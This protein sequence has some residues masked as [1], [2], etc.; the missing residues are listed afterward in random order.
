MQNCASGPPEKFHRTIPVDRVVAMVQAEPG[1]EQQCLDNSLSVVPDTQ[2]VWSN[3]A[4]PVLPGAEVGEASRRRP[5]ESELTLQVQRRL[6]TTRASPSP[7]PPAPPLGVSSAPSQDQSTQLFPAVAQQKRPG[8]AQLHTQLTRRLEG[9]LREQERAGGPAEQQEQGAGAGAVSRPKGRAPEPEHGGDTR[10]SGRKSSLSTPVQPESSTGASA[11]SKKPQKA[12]SVEVTSNMMRFI[13]SQYRTSTAVPWC[14]PTSARRPNSDKSWACPSMEKGAAK[15]VGFLKKANDAKTPADRPECDVFSFTSES[16]KSS[17]QKGLQSLEKSV[18]EKRVKLASSCTTPSARTSTAAKPRGNFARKHLFSDTE[19]EKTD[20]SWLRESGR[21]PKPRVLDY[22]RQRCAAKPPL[23]ADS[24]YESDLPPPSSKSLEKQPKRKQKQ[25]KNAKEMETKRIAADSK[26]SGRPQ[27]STASSKNYREASDSGSSQSECDELTNHRPK[28]VQTNWS[29]KWS[30]MDQRPEQPGQSPAPE[31]ERREKP[32]TAVRSGHMALTASQRRKKPVT[33]DERG[34]EAVTAGKSRKRPAIANRQRNKPVTAKEHGKHPVTASEEVERPVTADRLV[35]EPV[36]AS[37]LEKKPVPANKKVEKPVTASRQ[38]RNP[39]AAN[40][41]GKKSVFVEDQTGGQKGSWA[42]RLTDFALSPPPMER[43]RSAAGESEALSESLVSPVHSPDALPLPLEVAP[44]FKGI[45]ASSF[46]RADGSN[47]KGRTPN[48]PSLSPLGQAVPTPVPSPLH[49]LQM[50]SPPLLTSTALEPSIPNSPLLEESLGVLPESLGPPAVLESFR[51]SSSLRSISLP[52]KRSPNEYKETAQLKVHKSGPG[53]KRPPSRHVSSV[54]GEEEEEEEEG[55]R[56]GTEPRISMRPR[57][58]F[59]ASEEEEGDEGYGLG[60][61]WTEKDKVSQQREATAAP[62]QG[63]SISEAEAKVEV[64]SVVSSRVVSSF[65]GS[66]MEAEGDVEAPEFSTSQY[67][68]SIC[69]QFSTELQRKMHNR[70][71]RMDQFAK[72]SL[73]SV[74]QHVSSVSVQI[75][76]CRSQKLEKIRG[77]L[78]EEIQSLEQ[79]NS[80]LKDME[81]ELTTYWRK[82]AQALRSY[83]E[84]ES[85]RLQNLKSVFQKNVSHSLEFEEQIFTSEMCLMREDI[86]AV[87][88]KLFKE[89]QEEEML[90]VRR[91]LQA[92]FLPDGCGF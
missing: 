51:S 31:E 52:K 45:Q 18:A 33:A 87:Q 56:P 41:Q 78:L 20:L 23:H 68:S 80:K 13:S 19:T 86:K 34:Q 36:A 21:K 24:A 75:H 37:E 76:Q 88:D 11:H 66:N 53:R 35:K 64:C 81:K 4:P 8:S 69:R 65:W 54:S 70:S 3:R 43:M 2:P 22:S 39:V 63:Q 49:P 32:V 48:A 10:K 44:P 58:L 73:K 46:Y 28:P 14:T 40:E 7:P 84:R 59:K 67:M 6:P 74:Q 9:L 72:Q 71:R 26:L 42:A 47:S 60:C 79:D 62:A 50:A 55:P 82:Q 92:L 61:S 5:S 15:V 17:R 90:S 91:G 25:R 85:K 29:T 83:Q 16:P 38:T 12:T 30:E 27:R 77:V 57:K 89:M 1:S